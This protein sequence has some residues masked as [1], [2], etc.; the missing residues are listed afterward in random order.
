M[1]FLLLLLLLNIP[2]YINWDRDAVHRLRLES[3][4]FLN[5]DRL[6]PIVDHPAAQ[7]VAI[8]SRV[9]E[10]KTVRLNYHRHFTGKSDTPRG[11]KGCNKRLEDSK[12]AKRGTEIQKLTTNS[13]KNRKQWWE[14]NSM[15]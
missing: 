13:E 14:F 7:S 2:V 11:I 1:F 4:V 9:D 15:S 3:S 6:N 5:A 10:R 12:R 8:N